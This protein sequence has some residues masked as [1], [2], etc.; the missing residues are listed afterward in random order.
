M[1]IKKPPSLADLCDSLMTM[2]G[3]KP[4]LNIAIIAYSL[5]GSCDSALSQSQM[6]A[7]NF[8][9]RE[10]FLSVAVVDPVAFLSADNGQQALWS[11]PGPNV[12][13]LIPRHEGK[14]ILPKW[15]NYCFLFNHMLPDGE[16]SSVSYIG[17]KLAT[18]E[19]SNAST[20]GNVR[21]RRI[22]KWVRRNPNRPQV[23]EK[24]HTTRFSVADFISMQGKSLTEID[25]DLGV[26]WHGVPKGGTQSSF[27]G[28]HIW[29]SPHE[30]Y[31]KLSDSDA[32]LSD[33]GHKLSVSPFPIPGLG[34][35]LAGTSVMTRFT[36][37]I[38]TMG[39]RSI[40]K[41]GEKVGLC[42]Q[43][44]SA[45]AGLLRVYS[46]L[47]NNN[48]QTDYLLIFDKNHKHLRKP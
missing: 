35:T 23:N 18:L 31:A 27:S 21:L 2:K 3:F 40:M 9:M 4:Y 22:G 17:L 39:V 12:Y 38:P 47:M 28:R 14:N 37:V 30:K 24:W 34:A 13:K 26:E 10:A 48:Q 8:Y 41:S 25:R 45:Y 11:L 7:Q 33:I 43:R 6:I 32:L 29:L 20:G 1:A 46:P 42:L 16:S 15:E 36:S 44:H 19:P 5:L